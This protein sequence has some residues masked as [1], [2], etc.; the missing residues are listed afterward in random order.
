[1]FK[2]IV[3]FLL[4]FSLSAQA[5]DL[6]EYFPASNTV[7]LTKT[8]GSAQS[9]YT[10]QANN[11]G[12]DNL[13]QNYFNLNK[14]GYHYMWKKEYWKNGAWCTAT[15][16]VLYMGDDL[17]VTEVGDWYSDGT[18]TPKIALGYKSAAGVAT[19]LAWAPP[20]GITLLPAIKEMNVWRQNTP[21]SAYA[22]S[23]YQ[24]YNKSGY[25][26]VLPTFT[27]KYGRSNN[28]WGEGNGQTYNDV[29]HLVMYHGTKAPTG[30]P[31][32]CDI[33]PLSANGAY[34]Q[35][36]KNF[37]SYAIE[38]WMA[39]GVGIIQERFPFAESGEEFGVQNCSGYLFTTPQ[40]WEWYIDNK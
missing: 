16:A 19:G 14:T 22:N 15:Y 17:S 21:G 13:Y 1:M 5:V 29:I 40:Y 23:G 4:L 20:G 10:L 30:S 31:I 38:L 37:N 33:P 26:E 25:I 36:Y 28:V 11:A 6:R 3:A 39:R 27:P 9:K 2:F 35:S 7:Y 32:R 24:A 18:C 8:D 12:L 34:Y